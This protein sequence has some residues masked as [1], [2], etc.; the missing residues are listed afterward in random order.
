MTSL[1]STAS[2]AVADPSPPPAEWWWRSVIG[3]DGDMTD[4]ARTCRIGASP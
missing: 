2:G 1:P 3:E 4:P